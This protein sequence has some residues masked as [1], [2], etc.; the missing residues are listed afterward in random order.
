MIHSPPHAHSSYLVHVE[1][2]HVRRHVA[3]YTHSALDEM[4]A[5]S[6]IRTLQRLCLHHGQHIHRQCPERFRQD[7]LLLSVREPRALI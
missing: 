3:T 1:I 6:L 5:L 4:L 7:E 2:A